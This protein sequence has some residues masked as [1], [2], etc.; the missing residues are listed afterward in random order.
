MTSRPIRMTLAALIPLLLVISAC[1]SD[2][3]DGAAGDSLP[4]VKIGIQDFPES[5]VLANLYGTALAEEG[6]D[7]S[8]KELGGY[9]DILYA[10]FKSGDVN[11]TLDYASSALEFL[12]KQA[13]EA[14]PDIDKVMPLLN[15]QLTKLGLQSFDPAKAVDSNAFVVTKETAESKNLT[16]LSDLTPDLRLGGFADC[17]TNPFCIPGI[18]ELYGVDLSAHFVAQDGGDL[19]KTTLK[20][21]KIDVAVLTTTD[22]AIAENGWVVLT[23]DKGLINA[24]NIVPVLSDALARAGGTTLKDRVNKI[25]AALTTKDLTELN[26][27]FVV[28]KEDAD[29]I[30]E[31]WLSD[32]GFR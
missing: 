32:N 31:D 6:F 27:L 15:T 1:T 10:S 28:D 25:S 17:P 4:A 20:G 23:D 8:Y 24:D 13:G 30:A 14:S 19:T 26:R 12:N 9:R 29:Q 16:S 3:S 18:K 7:V 2:S 22:P 21:K 5:K 11:F